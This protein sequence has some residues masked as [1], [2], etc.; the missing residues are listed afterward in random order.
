MDFNKNI[1]DLLPSYVNNTLDEASR[2]RLENVLRNSP[3]L[4]AEVAWLQ[5]VRE[6]MRADEEQQLLPPNHAGLD[7]LMARIAAEKS[8]KLSSI[9]PSSKANVRWY[10]PALA[11][12]ATVMFVQAIGL[13]MVLNNGSAPDSIR[14]LSGGAAAQPGAVLQVTFKPAA[15][16]AQIRA[17]LS[18]VDGEIIGGPG[19]LGVYNIRVKKGQGASAANRLLQEKSVVDTATVV[20]N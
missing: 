3:A 16:E 10:K 17:S 13:F 1:S 6:Q 4:Q 18:A 12:A 2:R 14:M 7:R 5:R 9:Q 19:V 11:I 20:Q 8:G 15:A